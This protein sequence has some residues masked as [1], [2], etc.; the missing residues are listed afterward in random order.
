M[1]DE[2]GRTDVGFPREDPEGGR[3]GF[4]VVADDQIE[5]GPVARRQRDRLVYVIGRHQLS[6]NAGG[7]AL[8]ERH[9]LSELD[10]SGLVRDAERKELA[11]FIT[12]TWRGWKRSLHSGLAASSIARCSAGEA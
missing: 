11:H 10:R 8:R 12:S 9:A 2:L 3:L 5:L 4:D 1:R 7:A 6:Q